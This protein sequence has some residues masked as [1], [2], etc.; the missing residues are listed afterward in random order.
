MGREENTG[1]S[2]TSLFESS[3]PFLPPL[4]CCSPQRVTSPS[5]RPTFTARGCHFPA[6]PTLTFIISFQHLLW[7]IAALRNGLSLS[8]FSAQPRAPHKLWALPQGV[9]YSC[10]APDSCLFIPFAVASSEWEGWAR[11]GVCQ[12][13]PKQRD[14]AAEVAEEEGQSLYRMSS[15]WLW[16]Q[17]HQEQPWQP[18]GQQSGLCPA[19]HPCSKDT[20]LV[21]GLTHDH[22]AV[23][24]QAQDVGT[25]SGTWPISFHIMPSFDTTIFKVTFLHSAACS[26]WIVLFE[27]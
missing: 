5:N 18:S 22:I 11:D 7:V 21:Q 19:S 23:R 10:G 27:F 15:H 9:C 6:S 1:H 20:R 3:A 24:W 26:A 14:I 16:S 12:N 8:F 17:Q 2:S 25:Q 4:P 13:C